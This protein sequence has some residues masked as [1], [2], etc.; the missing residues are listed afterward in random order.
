MWFGM[1]SRARLEVL[2]SIIKYY[3]YYEVLLLLDEE[4]EEDQQDVDVV[5]DVE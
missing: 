3:H 1:S 5:R 4:D 2:L